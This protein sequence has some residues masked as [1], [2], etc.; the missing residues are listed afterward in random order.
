VKAHFTG[1]DAPRDAIGLF[2]ARGHYVG[3][4]PIEGGRWNI[5]MSVPARRVHEH[6]GEL[7]ELFAHVTRENTA[8]A[9]QMRRSERISRWLTSPLPRF[10]V[11]NRWP[12]SIIP[13]GNA[14]AALEPIGGEGMGLAM[15]SAEL[16]TQ[17]LAVGQPIGDFQN[18]W[19]TRSLACR[20]AALAM[21]SP[22]IARCA[23]AMSSSSNQL[24]RLILRLIGKTSVALS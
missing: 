15:R 19:R 20:A 11:A 2:G 10:S 22:R 9:R 13:L 17:L 5:A 1:V 24:N 8:L 23:I 7:D 18:L 14:A 16:V 4:A 3:L 6:R 12:K 21:S